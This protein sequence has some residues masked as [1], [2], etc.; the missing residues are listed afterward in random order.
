MTH[1]GSVDGILEFMTDPSFQG[2]TQTERNDMAAYVLCFDTGTAPAVGYTRT[3]TKTT[4]TTTPVQ[5]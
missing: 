4:V 5:S 1:D 2:Y 3:L